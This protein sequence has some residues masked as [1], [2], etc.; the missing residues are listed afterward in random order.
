[1]VRNPVF[2]AFRGHHHHRVM[3]AACETN[4]VHL[5]GNRAPI[6]G[7]H[8]SCRR[9]RHSIGNHS[10]MACCSFFNP[11]DGDA[12]KLTLPQMTIASASAWESLIHPN[13][14]TA[15]IGVA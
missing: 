8:S 4:N 7:H 10:H 5:G 3:P 6:Y 13:H 14:N 9:R 12:T 1:M 11:V 2:Y 15:C